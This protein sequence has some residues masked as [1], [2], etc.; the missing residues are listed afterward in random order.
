[1]IGL[2]TLGLLGLAFGSGP[3][4]PVGAQACAPP[5]L[6]IY[7]QLARDGQGTQIYPDQPVVAPVVA[8]TD[9][10]YFGAHGPD[11]LDTDGDGAPDTL[12]ID[13]S[14]GEQAIV[15]T[16]GDGVVRVALA[17]HQLGTAGP[18]GD[19]D[20]DGRDEVYFLARPTSSGADLL[21]ILPGTT[22][23]GTYQ[24]TA[25]GIRLPAAAIA[26]VG[27]QVVGPG[28]DLV[29]TEGADVFISAGSGVMATPAGGTLASYGRDTPLL[30]GYRAGVFLLGDG[31]PSVATVGTEG[32]HTVVS[33]WR[34]GE[35]TRYRTVGRTLEPNS[36]VRAIL[37][38]SGPILTASETDRGSSAMFYW[39]LADPC[40]GL[41]AAATPAAPIGGAATYTG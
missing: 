25:A 3:T 27:D 39:N 8:G 33:L 36:V 35:V 32:D 6:P 28:E 14:T 38:A 31:L 16:R 37:T 30:D 22:S 18:V 13:G 41:S 5:Y 2:A 19:L 4:A 9:L 23:P 24:A 20:G 10:R 1:M 40:A 26:P 21:F 11:R 7:G 15:I 12:E 17:G 29:V 34:D